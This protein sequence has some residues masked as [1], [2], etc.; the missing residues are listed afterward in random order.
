MK[1]F[2]NASPSEILD[3]ICH[4][5]ISSEL[6]KRTKYIILGKPGC[7]G[8]TWLTDQLRERGYNSTEITEEVVGLVNFN[9]DKN[10][11]IE[12]PYGRHMIIVLNKPYKPVASTLRLVYFTRQKAE[13]TLCK[14]MDLLGIYGHVSMADYYDLIGATSGY[15]DNKFGWVNLDSAKVEKRRFGICR[16]NEFESVE[17]AYVIKLPQPRPLY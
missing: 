3:Y 13:Q 8:K 9:D 2:S 1:D 16:R 10:H 4:H 12:D 17:N 6:A 15:T 14:M 7:T 11:V 5:C